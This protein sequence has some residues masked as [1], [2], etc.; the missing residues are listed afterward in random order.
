MADDP[1]VELVQS[2]IPGDADTGAQTLQSAFPGAPP[3]APR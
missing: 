2:T 3:T 1:Q